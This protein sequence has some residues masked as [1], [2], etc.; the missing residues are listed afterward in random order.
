VAANTSIEWC[1]RS[2]NPVRGC[3]IVSPGCHSCYAMKQAHRFAGPGGSYEGLTKRTERS[4]PQWTGKVITVESALLEPLS[5]RKPARVFVNSMSDLFHEDVP[6]AFIDKVFAVMALAD[7]H[8]FQVLTKRADRMRA[9]M[10]DLN[11]VD[12]IDEHIWQ[13]H[14]ESTTNAMPIGGVLPN[15]WLGVSV[16]NQQYADERIPLLL[17]TPAAVR[18]IS[19]EPLL[20]PL[21]LRSYVHN[22]ST[23]HVS[24]DVEGAIKNRACD[25]LTDNGRPMSP[26]E[27]ETALRSLVA[28][29][30]KRIK[31]TDECVGFSDQ[32]GCPGHRHRRVDWVIVGGES[33]PGA[34]PFD[35]AWARSIVQQCKAAGV[36]CFVKQVG[37]VPMM[38]DADWRSE[39][40]DGRVR[41]LSATNHRRVPDG[42]VP[43]AMNRKGGDPSEWP[44]DIRVRQFPEARA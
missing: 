12:R 34:R 18:F 23:Y 1:D 22:V 17:Q 15:V 19:A 30:V 3:S 24:V 21:D 26:E 35:L 13:W 31:S 36:A 43:I 20:G 40:G 32:T 14:T 44:E 29:G 33:G 5:W 37:A 16:E 39:F 38:G 42:F 4:G 10:L 28:E 11:R 41:I 2:W 8:T 25:F 7:R 27:A 9:Y 6:D